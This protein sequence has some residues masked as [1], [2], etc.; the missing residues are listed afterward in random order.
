MDS[1]KPPLTG[2]EERG[3]MSAQGQPAAGVRGPLLKPLGPSRLF[4]PAWPAAG[5]PQAAS[6]QAGFLCHPTHPELSWA[7]LLVVLSCHLEILSGF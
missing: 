7:Q 1:P 3:R 5:Q 6:V 2:E 4:F